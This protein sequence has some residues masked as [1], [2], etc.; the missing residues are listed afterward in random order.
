MYRKSQQSSTQSLHLHWLQD[1][2]I[3]KGFDDFPYLCGVEEMV[4]DGKGFTFR[5]LRGR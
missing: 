1:S 5:L 3:Y 4:C 2:G